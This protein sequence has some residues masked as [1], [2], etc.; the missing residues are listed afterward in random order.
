MRTP[1][2]VLLLATLTVASACG[3]SGDSATTTPATTAAATTIA[4]TTTAATSTTAAATTTTVPAPTLSREARLAV[5]R[6][7]DATPTILAFN[8]GYDGGSALDD[9]IA[10]CDEALTQVTTDLKGSQLAIAISTLNVALANANFQAVADGEFDTTE[11]QT[12]IAALNTAHDDITTELARL[13]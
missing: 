4:A 2:T 6:C 7:L 12:L 1:A 3:G 8:V 10:L 13:D 5:Q 11:Q 9:P